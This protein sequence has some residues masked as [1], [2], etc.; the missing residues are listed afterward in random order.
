MTTVDPEH[1]I[2]YGAG[3]PLAPGQGHELLNAEGDHVESKGGLPNSEYM[4]I[5]QD[6]QFVARRVRGN[7]S[8]TTSTTSRTRRMRDMK[9]F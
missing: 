8:R 3:I 4:D 1:A 7:V 5:R 2:P 9:L 6:V